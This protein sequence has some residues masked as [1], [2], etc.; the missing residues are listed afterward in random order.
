MYQLMPVLVRDM[1][2][3][4]PELARQQEQIARIIQSE[5]KSFLQTL[6][7]GL[8]RFGS[9]A[10]N[11]GIINGEDAFE[12]YDTFGFPSTSPAYSPKSRASPSTR[13]LHYRPPGPARP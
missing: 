13:R 11:E 6:E 8:F 12:L 7:T 10:T 4:F 9:L 5:E 3:A 2:A 1:G